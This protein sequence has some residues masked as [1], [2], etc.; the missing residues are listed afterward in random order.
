MITSKTYKIEPF[1]ENSFKKTVEELVECIVS[2]Y[3]FIEKIENNTYSP[4]LVRVSDSITRNFHKPEY[5]FVTFNFC[6]EKSWTN[7]GGHEFCSFILEDKSK[8]L[9]RWSV[10]TDGKYY[11]LDKKL[12]RHFKLKKIN[13]SDILSYNL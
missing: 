6:S 3:N 4:E 12:L 5:I 1:V 11:N 7:N 2:K 8:I 13:N 9:V 10:S